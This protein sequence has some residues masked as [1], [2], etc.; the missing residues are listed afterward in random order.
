MRMKIVKFIRAAGSWI[1]AFLEVQLP[2]DVAA[3]RRTR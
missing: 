3:G 1:S 2:V